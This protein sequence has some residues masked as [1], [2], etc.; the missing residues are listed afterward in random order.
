[1]YAKVSLLEKSPCRFDHISRTVYAIDEDRLIQG[2]SFSSNAE[3]GV[4]T[5]RL[6]IDVA[7]RVKVTLLE[8]AI[9]LEPK[10][11]E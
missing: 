6:V 5:L 11:I 4:L 7:I 8:L 9:I 2:W 1:M 10:M 3:K